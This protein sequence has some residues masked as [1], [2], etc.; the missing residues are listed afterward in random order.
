MAETNVKSVGSASGNSVADRA[1]K[2]SATRAITAAKMGK[3]TDAQKHAYR[4]V[5]GLRGT[6][7][8]LADHI[9]D[10]GH[11][12]ADMVEACAMLDFNVGKCLFA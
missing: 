4:K 3:L 9:L 1:K 10:G 5:T 8:N 7:D 11:V 12:T 6:I 2:A